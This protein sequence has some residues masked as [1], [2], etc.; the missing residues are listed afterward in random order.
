MERS[1]GKSKLEVF[2]CFLAGFDS[3][4]NHKSVPNTAKTAYLSGLTSNTQS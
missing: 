3:V 4:L 1:W 2:C